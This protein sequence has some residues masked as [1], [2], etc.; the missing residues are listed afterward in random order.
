MDKVTVGVVIALLGAASFIQSFALEGTA[1]Y[2]YF[3]VGII[4]AI[5]GAIYAAKQ[6]RD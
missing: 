6:I 4:L 1:Q 5:G 3:S 2:V